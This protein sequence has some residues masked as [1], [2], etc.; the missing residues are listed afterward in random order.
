MFT[1]PTFSPVPSIEERSAALAS[2]GFT[3]ADGAEWEWSEDTSPAY[4]PH[5]VH[6]ALMAAAKVQPVPGGAA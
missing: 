4:H 3:L 2:L 5:P 6:V 1:W